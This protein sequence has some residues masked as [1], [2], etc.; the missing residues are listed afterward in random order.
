MPRT[1]GGDKAAT[2]PLLPHSVS[3]LPG[4]G[5]SVI[6]DSGYHAYY[7]L[8]HPV[9]SSRPD[10]DRKRIQDIQRRWVGLVGG[11]DG[12]KDLAR[13]LRIPGT[14]NSKYDPARTL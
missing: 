14:L 8:E 11:D 3:S 5:A 6:I 10:S 12:A 9:S 13:V 2:L 7:L 1:S 4:G